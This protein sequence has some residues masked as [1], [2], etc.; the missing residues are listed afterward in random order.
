[1]AALAPKGAGAIPRFVD[2]VCPAA[3]G[4]APEQ[5]EAV[6]ARLRQVAVAVGL[7][8]AA[9]GCAPNAFV[10]AA[11]DKRAFV[12]ALARRRPKAFGVLGPREV[13][14]LARAPGPAV[15]WQLAGAGHLEGDAYKRYDDVFAGRVSEAS[16]VEARA[17]ANPR[18]FDASV[19]VVEMKALEGLTVTQL[20]DYAAMRLFAKLDPARL[21]AGAPPT[22]LMALDAPAGSEVPV[23]MTRW[24]AGFLKGLYASGFERSTAAQRAAI[25]RSVAKGVAAPER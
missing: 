10:V 21:G 14:R 16:E 25:G 20:A 22:I 17:R 4:L 11:G 9:E 18:G 2:A 19:L 5:N 7:K 24:D 15:A 12:E 13:V 23:T 8:A 6:A 3:W 1:M